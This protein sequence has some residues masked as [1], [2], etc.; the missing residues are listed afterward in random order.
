MIKAIV[1]I[2]SSAVIISAMLAGPAVAKSDAEEL[3]EY[4]GNL[5]KGICTSNDSLEEKL[6]RITVIFGAAS[7]ELVVGDPVYWTPEDE[8]PEDGYT[9]LVFV[10]EE[11]IKNCPEA[12]NTITSE[13]TRL[14]RLYAQRKRHVNINSPVDQNRENLIKSDLTTR[15]ATT[16]DEITEPSRTVSTT[17]PYDQTERPKQE[18]DYPYQTQ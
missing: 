3:A 10:A 9:T 2:F 8:R 11:I 18:P 13:L 7:T 5:A 14:T 15:L 17:D 1:N 6:K 16:L 4:Y 12:T